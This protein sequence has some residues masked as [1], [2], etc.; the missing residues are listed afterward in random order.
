MLSRALC[1]ARGVN[2]TWDPVLE[3]SPLYT[4]Y[5]V[6]PHSTQRYVYL[7]L[8][9]HVKWGSPHFCWLNKSPFFNHH[10]CCWKTT[11]FGKI[12]NLCGWFLSTFH[13]IAMSTGGQLV[14]AQRLLLQC[15][16]GCAKGSCILGRPADPGFMRAIWSNTSFWLMMQNISFTEIAK[17]MG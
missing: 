12:L 16:N 10:V 9:P 6:Y 1:L 14:I 2:F 8:N 4:F 11:I 3:T 5:S 15:Q 17:F 13:Y 7:S